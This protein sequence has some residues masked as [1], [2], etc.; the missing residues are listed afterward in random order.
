MWSNVEQLA[1]PAAALNYCELWGVT[2]LELW[3]VR[4][5]E[6][7]LVRLLELLMLQLGASTAVAT[8]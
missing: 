5:L 4:L 8:I 1:L 7:W 6:L 2:L 3:L